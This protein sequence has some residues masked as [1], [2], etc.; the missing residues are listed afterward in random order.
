MMP[1]EAEWLIEV[2]KASARV[3]V[4]LETFV[5]QW[6]GQLPKK[7][8]KDLSHNGAIRCR[9][10]GDP[11]QFRCLDTGRQYFDPGNWLY[12]VVLS[13]LVPE[14]C[15]REHWN[16]ETKGDIIESVMGCSYLKDHCVRHSCT[17]QRNR[18]RKSVEYVEEARR[19][20]DLF[21]EVAWR[22]HALSV[23][24]GCDQLIAWVNWVMS[25]VYFAKSGECRV[26]AV[27]ELDSDMPANM[28]LLELQDRSKGCLVKITE[29]TI[30]AYSQMRVL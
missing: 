8:R 3:Q 16:I 30:A 28:E 9:T 25:I 5:E 11:K 23:R 27:C 4:P 15:R 29:G 7:V 26:H 12:A 21:E 22:T 6:M 10:E 18:W 24:V 20:A 14:C 1:V 17:L 2:A 19:V 13:I